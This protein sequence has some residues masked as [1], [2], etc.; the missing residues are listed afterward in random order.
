MGHVT[1]AFRSN[2][3]HPQRVTSHNSA[4]T[5]HVTWSFRVSDSGFIGETKFVFRQFSVGDYRGTF[6][7]EEA[8]IV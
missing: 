8:L 3:T 2:V 4:E 5:D 6:V 1:S 7:V